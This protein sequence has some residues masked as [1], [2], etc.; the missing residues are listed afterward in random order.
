LDCAT[1][2]SGKKPRRPEGLRG[3]GCL[4]GVAP[5][6]QSDGYTPSSRH[7]SQPFTRKQVPLEFSDSSKVLPLR[8]ERLLLVVGFLLRLLLCQGF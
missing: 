7:A 2:G 5:Q 1:D 3:N 8:V 4:D 6:S